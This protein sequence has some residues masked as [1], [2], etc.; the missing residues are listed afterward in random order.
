MM[1]DKEAIDHV[2]EFIGTQLGDQAK[3]CREYDI[4]PSLISGILIGKRN[5]TPQVAIACGLRKVTG[6]V[7]R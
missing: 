3:F 6:Y 7:R 5:L 4:S 1:T 2:R